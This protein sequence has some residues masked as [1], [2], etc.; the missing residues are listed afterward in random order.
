MLA[1]CYLPPYLLLAD[2]ICSGCEPVESIHASATRDAENSLLN[3][4]VMLLETHNNA[5]EK[6]YTAGSKR[7][8]QVCPYF[9]SKRNVDVWEK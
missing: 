3:S 1:P 7:P 2:S 4:P 8:L 5:S 9:E 6:V